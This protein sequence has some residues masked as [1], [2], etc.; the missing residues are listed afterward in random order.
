MKPTPTQLVLVLSLVRTKASKGDE[1][2]NEVALRKRIAVLVVAALI[3]MA[4]AMGA[5]VAS[6]DEAEAA[7]QG[8]QAGFGQAN[9]GNFTF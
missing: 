5:A 1:G 9:Q 8:A 7:V 4:G 6:A 3:A 2:R